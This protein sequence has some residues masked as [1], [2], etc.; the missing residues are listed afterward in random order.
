VDDFIF[1]TLATEELRLAHLR[2]RLAGVAHDQARFPRDPQPGQ[3]V[4][5]EL[6][7][8]PASPEGLPPLERAW[9]Y[10][11]TDGQD[12]QGEMGKAS[13]GYAVEMEPAG[14]EWDTLL[15]GYSQKFRIS[16][17][18]QPDDTLLRYRLSAGNGRQE[19]FADGGKYYGCYIAD[20]PLPAWSKDA[21]VYQIF[22][23]RFYPGGGQPW[24]KV[25]SL[26]DFYGGTLRGII[27]KLDY[28][29]TLGVTVLWLSPIFPSPSHHGYDATDYFQIEPRLG[30]KEDLRVLLREAHARSIRVLMDFVPNHWSHL[31]PTF[32]DAIRDPSSPYRE[33]YTFLRWPDKYESFFGVRSLPEINLRHPP[34]REHILDSVRYWLEFGVDGYRVDYAVGPTRDFWA[35]FRRA[36]RKAK[37]EP[38]TFGEAV[39]APDS[40]LSFQGGLDGCLDFILLE[41]I[42]QTFAF[43]RWSAAR[44]STFL[45]RHEAYFPPDFSRPSFLDNHDMNR[46]LWACRGDKRRLKIAALCQFSLS[47][48]P[49]IYQ[50]TE[51]GLSQARDIRQG[52]RGI[53]EEAR[54]PMDWGDEQDTDLMDFYIRLIDIRKDKPELRSGSRKV[55]YVD[56]DLLI[57]DITLGSEETIIALNLAAG[58]RSAILK[59]SGF[60]IDISTDAGCRFTQT[61]DGIELDLPP[62]SGMLLS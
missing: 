8:G 46:F 13:H 37:A 31:H 2:A 7:I 38:W 15:W 30:T 6:T 28:I 5:F 62:L 11:S 10:W 17:P 19:V 20:D 36:T 58:N 52:K 40:Q 16:L 50:G 51:V 27:E 61:T 33:W 26:A 48:P 53:L 41:A 12:P 47:G 39:E 25:K 35:D 1:G 4:T 49:V 55:L 44:F 54:Q 21:I 45:D 34:A 24:N 60:N 59:K 42:R 57:Y 32:Q 29:S 23:D 22:V 9:L 18:G 14:I 43:G 56:E 3:P